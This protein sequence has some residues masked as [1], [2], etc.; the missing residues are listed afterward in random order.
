MT[1]CPWF[2]SHDVSPAPDGLAVGDVATC[3]RCDLQYVVGAVAPYRLDRDEDGSARVLSALAT[4]GKMPQAEYQKL[5][6]LP[7]VAR[8]LGLQKAGG[9]S[10]A[11][12][13]P[14]GDARTAPGGP[15]PGRPR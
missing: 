6:A 9:G 13:P 5:L 3:T 12:A 7:K 1:R 2:S 8:A 10:P 15:A 14:D 4:A 11:G